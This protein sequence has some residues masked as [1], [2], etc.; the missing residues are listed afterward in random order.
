[1]STNNTH[2]EKQRFRTET[3][4]G[5]YDSSDAGADIELPAT[6]CGA[7]RGGRERRELSNSVVHS[8]GTCLDVAVHAA[9]SRQSERHARRLCAQA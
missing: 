3:V 4:A 5:V 1:V 7:C 6:A 9:T 2:S 8:K